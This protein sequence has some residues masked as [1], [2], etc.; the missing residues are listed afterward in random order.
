VLLASSLPKLVKDWK[1]MT[2]TLSLS[3]FLRNSTLKTASSRLLPQQKGF[4]H[5]A[6]TTNRQLA[7]ALPYCNDWTWFSGDMRFQISGDMRLQILTWFS[8]DMRFQISGD[9]RLQ[10]L[11]WFSGDMRFQI[12]GDMRFQ[13]SG[14]MRLQILTWFSGDMRLEILIWFSIKV[15]TSRPFSTHYLLMIMEWIASTRAR[16]SFKSTFTASQLVGEA[17]PHQQLAVLGSSTTVVSRHRVVIQLGLGDDLTCHHDH[18]IFDDSLAGHLALG[19]VLQV[20]VKH[21]I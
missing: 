6:V 20:C 11:T 4:R 9:M 8:G 18:V 16:I 10:I 7:R 15:L 14:D 5:T 21:G 12:S 13:I 1:I 3:G 2:M 19:V 17:Q